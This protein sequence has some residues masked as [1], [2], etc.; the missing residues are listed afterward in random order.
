MPSLACTAK[1]TATLNDANNDNQELT[2]VPANGTAKCVAYNKATTQPDPVA[3][4]VMTKVVCEDE[5]DLPNYGVGNTALDMTS[6]TATDWIN[7]NV[8]K[9]IPPHDSCRLEPGWEFEYVISNNEPASSDVNTTVQGAPGTTFGPT[10][11]NGQT[12]VKF[13]AQD[14]GGKY[15]VWFREV[16]KPNYIPFTHEVTPN[17]S[18]NVSA[19]FYCHNDGYHY[20]N[21]EWV[22]SDNAPINPGNTYHCVAWNTPKEIPQTECPAEANLL[23]NGSFEEPVVSHASKWDIFS[24]VSG[25]VISWVDPLIE[26]T[27]KLELHRGVN[28]WLPFVGS[29][30]AELDSDQEGPSSGV[31]NTPGSVRIEQTVPT[32]IG[33]TYKLSYRFSPRPDNEHIAGE[34]VLKSYVDGSEVIHVGPLSSITNTAWELHTRTFT[35]DASSLIAFADGGKSNS[36]GT[37]L[38]DVRLCKVKDAPNE[39]TYL[40]EGYKFNDED[41]D[42]ERDEGEEGLAGWTIK[43]TDGDETLED[44]TDGDGYYSFQVPKGTWTVSE[45]QQSNW[46]QTGP[47]GGVCEFTFGDDA[48]VASLT[49]VQDNSCDFYNHYTPGDNDD[50]TDGGGGGGSPSPS[51]RAFET[52]LDGSEVT[53]TW[54][55]RNGREV[56]LLAN[57]VK[58]Y[59]TDDDEDVDGGSY[60]HTIGGVTNYELIVERGSKQ[61][62][63]RK[64]VLLGE[65]RGASDS[66]SSTQVGKIPKQEVAGVDTGAGGT[67]QTPAQTLP[68]IAL[69]AMIASLAV[70]R[71]TANE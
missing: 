31:N 20:D 71:K 51:C 69:L 9:H 17:D 55:T 39:K 28:G 30:Y 62:E 22:G 54:E 10:D 61:D 21:L 50:D 16:L 38:D 57:G 43:I 29:Q 12:S 53:L 3:T 70:I 14:L 7:G 67:S 46:T 32:E 26:A 58:I 18:N 24:S 11:A 59:S 36:V 48:R 49:Y 35:A 25:W 6:T 13:T 60:V 4:V 56:T 47:E 15:S 37:F 1:V 8:E 64:S 66:K 23:T 68:L 42:G 41:S 19:E 65:T 52:D 34:N 33:A 45:V 27:A 63:C 2:F 40:V 44:V 5:T